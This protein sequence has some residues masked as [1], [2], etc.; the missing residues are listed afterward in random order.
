MHHSTRNPEGDA[1][2]GTVLMLGIALGTMTLALAA[3]LLSAAVV[4]GARAGTAANLAA[5]AGADAL[6]GLRNGDA[7]TTAAA[8]AARNQAEVALCTPDPEE[9][10]V[11]VTVHAAAFLLPWP[12]SAEARAGPPPGTVRGPG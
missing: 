5:L 9:G 6:R 3:V 2:A 1:G 12:A 8:V 7:C 4:G 10:T 11:T